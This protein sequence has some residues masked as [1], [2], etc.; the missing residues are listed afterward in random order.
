MTDYARARET[1]VDTQVRTEG[2]TDHDIIRAMAEIPREAFVPSRLRPFAYIDD[3]LVVKEAAANEPGRYLMRPVPLARMLQAADVAPS[4]FMLIVGCPTGYAAAVAA[5]LAGAVI[6]LEEDE[7]LAAHAT[8]TLT[9]L[10]IDNV[11][12][13]TA[14]LEQGYPS[15]A[16][17]DV[18][19]LGGAVRLV[20]PALLAQL[21]VGGRLVG[22]VGYG[23]AARAMVYTHTD[24][25]F[26]ARSV[27]DAYLPPL[28]GF[29]RPETF[30]F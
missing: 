6:A 29:R 11:A 13:V 16:P 7:G 17:Y 23:R 8:E 2:V 28:P 18:I 27:F 24:G 26:G 20:P 1:M 9:E 15:E 30:V 5:R 10:G 22:V 19:L 3:D 12:V 21:R 4:D 25:D 14:P